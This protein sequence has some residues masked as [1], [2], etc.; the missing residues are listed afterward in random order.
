[1]VSAVTEGVQISVETTYR[2]NYSNPTKRQHLFS[3]SIRI[4]NKNDFSVQLLNRHWYIFDSVGVRREVKGPGVIGEQPILAAGAVYEYESA[5]HL[6]TEMGKMHGYYSMIRIHDRLP[7]TVEIPGFEL[8][9][10]YRLN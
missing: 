10:P 8:V 6:N 5:C 7:F 1:M 2:E 4:E 3:Y 9:T